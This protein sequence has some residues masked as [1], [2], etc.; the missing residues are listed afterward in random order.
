MRILT[1]IPDADMRSRH[2]G[3][4]DQAMRKGVRKKELVPGNLIVF[5]NTKKDRIMILGFRDEE[6]RFGIL[7][8]WRSPSGRVPLAAIQY[9][10]EHYGSKGLDMDAATK[11]ALEKLLRR[12]RKPKDGK[13]N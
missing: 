3:L 11:K 13:L 1:L 4:L 10:P 7:S 5:L 6:D 8:S 2:E 12:A 9:I